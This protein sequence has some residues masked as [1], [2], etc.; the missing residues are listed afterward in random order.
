MLENLRTL[1]QIWSHRVITLWGRYAGTEMPSEIRAEVTTL[2]SCCLQIRAAL[3]QEREH[4]MPRYDDDGRE[5]PPENPWVKAKE[6]LNDAVLKVER[7]LQRQ[8]NDLLLGESPHRD[9]QMEVLSPL[10]DK[11]QRIRRVHIVGG[12]HLPDEGIGIPDLRR[13]SPPLLRRQSR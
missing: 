1:T 10:L 6:R 7:S 2:E 5:L 9:A 13:S 12:M 11:L 3:D 8:V 4:T